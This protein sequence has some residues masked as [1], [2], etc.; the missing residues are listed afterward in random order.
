MSYASL[1]T[2]TTRHTHLHGTYLEYTVNVPV[3]VTL[4]SM[5]I[6]SQACLMMMNQSWFDLERLRTLGDVHLFTLVILETHTQGT[7][8]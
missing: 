6:H 3:I 1:G 8:A 5:H 7:S 2:C 4:R